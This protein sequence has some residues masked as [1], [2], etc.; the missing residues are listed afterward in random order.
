MSEGDQV[1]GVV[2]MFNDMIPIPIISNNQSNNAFVFNNE[3]QTTSGIAST[4][5]EILEFISP[6]VL[7]TKCASRVQR[8]LGILFS[9][10][11]TIGPRE[12]KHPGN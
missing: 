7:N 2:S 6:A 10:A 4:E 12:F 5:G 8:K 11:I 9:N 1:Y 3:V